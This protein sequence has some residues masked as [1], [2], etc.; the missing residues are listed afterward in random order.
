MTKP[1]Y[2]QEM[3]EELRSALSDNIPDRARTA[4]SLSAELGVHPMV[5]VHQIKRWIEE[6]TWER[7]VRNGQPKVY[8]YWNLTGDEVSKE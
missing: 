2:G 6:G 8:L 1:D 7:G 4:S 5:V 3:L